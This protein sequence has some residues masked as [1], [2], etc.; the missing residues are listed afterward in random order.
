MVEDYRAGLGVDRAA[1]DADRAAGRYLACPTLVAWS[2]ADDMQALYGDVLAV[3]RPWARDLR[4]VAIPS[5]HHM[6]E[7]APDQI[8][9]ALMGFLDSQ[10]AA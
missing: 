8:A 4:G 7:E 9:A 6:A 1:D 10:P 3:W 5:D 2:I